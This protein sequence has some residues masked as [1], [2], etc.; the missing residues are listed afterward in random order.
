MLATM[1]ASFLATILLGRW[2]SPAEFGEFAL[3]KSILLLGP[4]LAVFGLDQSF[5]KLFAHDPR[6]RVHLV[7]L[8]VIISIG[9]V[10][11][12]IFSK[13]YSLSS[14]QS[15]LV[16]IGIVSGAG[17][18]FLAGKLRL[19]KHFLSGQLIHGGWKLM[20]LLFILLA[21]FSNMVIDIDLVYLLFTGAM[22]LPFLFILIDFKHSDQSVV[23]GE[24]NN[25]K[26]LKSGLLFWMMSSSGLLFGGID[27]FMIPI[28]FDH[29]VLGI[30]SALGFIYIISFTMLGSA[31]GYVIFPTVSRGEPIPWRKLALFLSAV[32]I[33]AF[34]FFLPLGHYLVSLFF[35]GKYDPF[36]SQLIIAGFI[37]FGAMNMFHVILHFI[38]AGK[39]SSRIH[40]AYVVITLGLCLLYVLVMRISTIFHEAVIEKVLLLILLVWFVKLISMGFLLIRIRQ[41]GSS[42]VRD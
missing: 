22:L 4:T 7:V 12:L 34:A 16:W 18:L 17:S 3:L 33:A 28:V 26:F 1:A 27:K 20:F 25:R 37:L 13:L 24:N 31:I 2:L 14:G 38:I 11:T 8:A 42:V 29:E 36:N 21:W 35:D 39:G 32:T 19:L 23:R 40:T 10:V 9:V 30:Y 41:T 5:V 6:R 15:L